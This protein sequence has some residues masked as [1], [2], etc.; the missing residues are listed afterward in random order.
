MV[1]NPTETQAI[2]FGTNA[3]LQ[4]LCNLTS[5]EAAGTSVPLANSVKLIGA[6]FDSHLNFGKHISNV[7]FILFS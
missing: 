4:S 6:T 1:V 3:R 7:Y 2:C 5:I